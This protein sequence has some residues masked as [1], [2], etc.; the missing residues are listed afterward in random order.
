[1]TDD[2]TQTKTRELHF[3]VQ[4]EFI[5]RL[6]REKCY[7]E[8]DFKYAMT[9]LTSCLQNDKLSKA[10]LIGLAIQVLNGELDIRG[11]YPGPDYGLYE[12][13]PKLEE[14]DLFEAF[15]Q[16]K[17]ERDDAKEELRKAYLKF[18]LVAEDVPEYKQR[19]YNRIWRTDYGEDGKIFDVADEPNPSLLSA[20]LTASNP[21]PGSDPDPVADF[22]DRMHQPEDVG[23]DY[24]WLAPDGTFYPVEFAEHFKFATNWI[25]AHEPED[26]P[27]EDICEM[28]QQPDQT[29]INRGWVRLSNPSMGTARAQ[30]SD[31]RPLTERQKTFLYDYYM[32]R[33]KTLLAEQYLKED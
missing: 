28:I 20:F 32:T 4:G 14:Y 12:N 18:A 25:K 33:G 31:V 9:L 22:L 13:D 21:T 11:T 8:H 1:M 5:T 26:T 29:L 23:P 16:L 30:T 2:K 17:R 24:G 27:V 19:D 7:Q 3:S 15:A 10:E 6:A